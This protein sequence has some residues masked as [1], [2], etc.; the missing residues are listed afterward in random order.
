MDAD[1]YVVVDVDE[2]EHER[3]LA[4]QVALTDAARQLVDATI[5]TQVGAE[6]LDAVRGEL[7]ALV[8]RLR[9]SQLPGSYGVS[10]TSGG[11][12]RNYG[13]AVVGKRN[14]VAPPL[15]VER[16]PAGRAWSHFALGAAYEGPPGLV[17]GGVTALILDQ[18]A[19][20]AAAAGGT[21]GMTGQLNLRYER[22]TPLGPLSVEA[23]VDRREGYKTWVK[24]EMRD[25]EGQA[26]VTC[27]GLFILPRW[28]RELVDEE[29]KARYQR[30]G[31]GDAPGTPGD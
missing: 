4:S 6:E 24:G 31:A 3:F 21:P 9:T 8:A 27:E 22:P 30:T 29:T 1:Q 13:N 2:A 23:W 5:R 11:T 12:F 28:A 18:I 17:H 7:D 16:D 20:E 10:L 25:A 14:A 15:E 19:G 26:T